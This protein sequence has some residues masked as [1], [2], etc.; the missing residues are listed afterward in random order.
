MRMYHSR[1]SSIQTTSSTQTWKALYYQVAIHLI[2]QGSIWNGNLVM[3]RFFELKSWII[4]H[5][6]N[7]YFHF[8][9]LNH[10]ILPSTVTA[11]TKLKQKQKK[12]PHTA[13]C[14]SYKWL[15]VMWGA[16]IGMFK[17]LCYCCIWICMSYH[18]YKDIQ[19]N[20]I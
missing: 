11:F 16:N 8:C 14:L 18:V 17:F 10:N 7:K 15:F 6:L 13:S 3:S 5:I 19:S 9:Y 12:K 4:P 20:T 1:W 2:N